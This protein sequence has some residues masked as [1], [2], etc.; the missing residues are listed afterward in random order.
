M[1]LQSK[2]SFDS[3]RYMRSS[4]SSATVQENL[5]QPAFASYDPVS[6]DISSVGFLLPFMAG[7]DAK[8]LLLG[9]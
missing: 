4:K 7:K 9:R 1:A 3:A 5:M 6:H 2:E 8:T